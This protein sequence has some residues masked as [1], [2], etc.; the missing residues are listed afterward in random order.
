MPRT[1]QPWNKK[2]KAPSFYELFQPAQNLL[3]SIPLLEA[4]GNRPL[5]MNF[6]DQLKALVLYHLDEH[7]SGSHLLHVLEEDSFAREQIAPLDGIK[8]SSFFEAVNSRGLEQLSALFQKL[9]AVGIKTLP[10]EYDVLG[11]LIAIDGSLINATLSMYWADYRGGSKKAKAHLGFDLNRSIP[12]KIFLTHG[13]ASERAFVTHM[14]ALGETG[15]M[16]RGYQSH[17]TF[18]RLQTEG[19]HFLCR[20]KASTI[21]TCIKDNP[22]KSGS[23]VFYD[24]IVLLGTP[25]INQ[26]E[27]ELRVVGYRVDGIEYW[28]APSRYGLSAEQIALIYKLRWDI[29]TFFGWWKRHLKVYHL[30]AR[31]EY[32]LMVQILAGLITYLLLAIYC[33]KHYKEKV[34]IKRVRQLRIMIQNEARSVE[35]DQSDS[36]DFK[37]QINLYPYAKT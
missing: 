23:I 8:K 11:D 9:Q 32:G 27:K 20:I 15:V 19:K 29:E 13:K 18:D 36:I 16:D 3:P 1:L 33:H 31:S 34:S 30:I 28:V 25:G 4:R 5:Q 14:L 6:E 17:K 35:N 2:S 7:T 10:A 22:L 24:A 12:R 21:K 37:N 26:T